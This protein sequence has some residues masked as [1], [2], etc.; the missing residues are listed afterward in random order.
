MLLLIAYCECFSCSFSDLRSLTVDDSVSCL[1]IYPDYPE[2]DIFPDRNWFYQD[3]TSP[4]ISLVRGD[5]FWSLVGLLMINHEDQCHW[6]CSLMVPWITS[7]L[8]T[9]FLAAI[10]GKSYS[11]T[12]KLKSKCGPPWPWEW[13]VSLNFCQK[14]RDFQPVWAAPWLGSD[15]AET[16]KAITD[17]FQIIL[18]IRF[19]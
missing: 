8:P 9:H 1:H 17:G 10:H 11:Q 12:S 16:M 5:Q 7:F 13:G 4:V 15:K 19:W 2:S 18:S 14:M 6:H 3:K